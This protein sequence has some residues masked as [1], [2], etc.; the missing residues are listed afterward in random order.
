[1]IISLI[2]EPYFRTWSLQDGEEKKDEPDTLVFYHLMADILEPI[3]VML[4]EHHG[5]SNY[6]KL[7]CLFH[8]LFGLIQSHH[9]SFALRA[10]CEGNPP[11]I[12][13]IPS[14]RASKEESMSMS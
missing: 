6:W 14:Q 2:K 12:G 5:I 13:G 3:T 10:L 11:I 9:H 4:W 8:S 1:M 7:D